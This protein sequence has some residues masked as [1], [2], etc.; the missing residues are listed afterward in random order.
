MA[1]NGPY[2][3]LPQNMITRI[4][5]YWALGLLLNAQGIEAWSAT[6]WSFLGVILASDCLGRADGYDRGLDDSLII[7]NRLQRQLKDKQ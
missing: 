6:W 3:L 4:A 1:V 7:I 5:L 2:Y